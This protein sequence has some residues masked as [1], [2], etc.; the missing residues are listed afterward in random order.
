M[1]VD[2]VNTTWVKLL[3]CFQSVIYCYSLNNV[4]KVFQLFTYN[5]VQPPIF[6][7]ICLTYCFNVSFNYWF[8]QIYDWMCQ[9]RNLWKSV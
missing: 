2:I 3:D 1:S 6:V 7:M 9:S 4:N 5:I 8:W